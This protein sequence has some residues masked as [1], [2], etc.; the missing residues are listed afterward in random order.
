MELARSHETNS[1]REARLKK[2]KHKPTAEGTSVVESRTYRAKD[3]VSLEQ[4][5]FKKWLLG[6]RR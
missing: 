1:S 5:A 6:L 3:S 2:E 4:S